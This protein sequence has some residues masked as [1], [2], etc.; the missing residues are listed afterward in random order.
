MSALADVCAALAEGT[1]LE[2]VT[3]ESGDDVAE[4]VRRLRVSGA[5]ITLL[6]IDSSVPAIDRAM[7]CAAIGPLAIERAPRARI[8]AIE[9][10][11]GAAAEDVVAAASYLG[12]ARSTT[13]QILTITATGTATG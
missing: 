9:I 12:S 2:I 11:N 10:G 6:L 13:G 8:G 7:L 5:G 1:D 3:A 4:I